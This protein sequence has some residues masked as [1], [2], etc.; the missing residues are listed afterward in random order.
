MNAESDDVDNDY[1]I[2]VNNVN[3]DKL[4]QKYFFDI[5]HGFITF[6]NLLTRI[7]DSKHF[8]RLRYLK[9]L[10]PVVYVYQNATHTRFEH[11]LGAAHYAEKAM[12][13]I[14]KN[15]EN[16]K[17]IM[18]YMASIKELQSYY[19]RKYGGRKTPID[20]YIIMLVKIAG[21]CHD[22]GHGPYSHIF[23]DI[24]IKKYPQ[25]GKMARHEYRSCI[26][27]EHIIKNDPLLSK[28]I[29]DPEIEF[30]KNIIDPKEENTGFIY[31]IVSNDLN[32][33]DVD[34]YDYILRDSYATGRKVAFNP[35]R[36]MEHIKIHDNNIC[37]P[38]KLAF[39]IESLFEARYNLFKTVYVHK[40][41]IGVGMLLI[42]IMELLNEF[43][44]FFD[45]IMDIDKFADM[46]DEYVLYIAQN[47][48]VSD[49][50][51]SDPTMRI[52][53]DKLMRYLDNL[54]NHILYTK[55]RSMTTNEE[56][57]FT[58]DVLKLLE[59]YDITI[60]KNKIGYV[61]GN[62]K[63]PF[64]NIYFYK[65]HN[66]TEK[67]YKMDINN[68]TKLTPSNYQE[69]ITHLFSRNKLD[70]RSLKIINDAIDGK[71][72]IKKKK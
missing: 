48:K 67:F 2:D 40:T 65:I 49:E 55:V 13:T 29:Y 16:K 28:I 63:N 42:D 5:I 27:L 26:I 18:D 61:S 39:D 34:K 64:D 43:F 32:S 60:Y 31:Q 15:K 41:V 24:F 14:L 20:K 36:L 70:D 30:I 56:I 10:G 33:L 11:S 59:S 9:Q 35:Q 25:C 50:V 45:Y 72:K 17:K 21:L 53:Y 69:H 8:Q 44:D 38:E 68:Y 54:K 47:L 71:N 1:D 46:T 6:D 66:G 23:D 58:D 19:N 4:K 37:Y 12:D 51:L 57:V 7:I 3:H 52:K 22:L 62:K